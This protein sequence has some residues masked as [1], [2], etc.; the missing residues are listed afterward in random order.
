MIESADKIFTL[1]DHRREAGLG[2]YIASL[3]FRNPVRIG[4]RNYLQSSLSLDQMTIAHELDVESVCRV[5]R[6]VLNCSHNK[7]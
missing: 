4:I 6:K 5:V 2:S 7:T 3:G 1:E